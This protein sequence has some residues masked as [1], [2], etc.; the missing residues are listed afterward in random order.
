MYESKVLRL[1]ST[2]AKNF[3]SWRGVLSLKQTIKLI[4]SWTKEVS[5]KTN[6]IDVCKKQI[7]DYLK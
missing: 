6:P 1:D 3:L 2:K 4:Y 7:L 5:Q